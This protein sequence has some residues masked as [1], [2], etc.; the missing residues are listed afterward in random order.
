MALVRLR[1]SPRE[2]GRP[3][4]ST[5]QPLLPRS[6]CVLTARYRR[7]YRV[8]PRRTIERN[9]RNCR[10]TPPFPRNKDGERSNR[11]RKK[12]KKR[13]GSKERKCSHW[14]FFAFIIRDTLTSEITF[15]DVSRALCI[16]LSDPCTKKWKSLT[17]TF[18]TRDYTHSTQRF[19]TDRIANTT[20]TR[21]TSRVERTVRFSLNFSSVVLKAPR[22]SH[23]QSTVPILFPNVSS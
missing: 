15:H 16:T 22:R 20:P 11:V 6:P 1:L 8:G 9:P 19:G 21:S 10:D 18:V 3:R 2:S 13:L 12:R 14:A 23:G 4:S 17:G 7:G 5:F